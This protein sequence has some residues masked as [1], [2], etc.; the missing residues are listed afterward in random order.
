MVRA[1]ENLPVGLYDKTIKISVISME[2]V[3]LLS[4]RVLSSGHTPKCQRQ[5]A[6]EPRKIPTICIITRCQPNSLSDD[7]LTIFNGSSIEAIG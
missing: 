5:H 3:W 4:V 2:V 6:Y 7:C 1:E